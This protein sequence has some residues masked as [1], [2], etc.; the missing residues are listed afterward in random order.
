[1][2]GTYLVD[3]NE[4]NVNCTKQLHWQTV[5]GFQTHDCITQDILQTITPKPSF[6]E[7]N[8]IRIYFHFKVVAHKLPS[9]LK[10]IHT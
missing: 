8:Q 7:G 9:I 1:M 2:K 10:I 3:V 6:L 5:I 4:Q